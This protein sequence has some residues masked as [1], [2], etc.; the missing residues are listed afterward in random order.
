MADDN[1]PNTKPTV[2]RVRVYSSAFGIF[3]IVNLGLQM[4][5]TLLENAT[6]QWLYPIFPFMG[7]GVLVITILGA[8]YYIRRKLD[9]PK[10]KLWWQILKLILLTITA[11]LLAM[12]AWFSVIEADLE[13]ARAERGDINWAT[14]TLPEPPTIAEDKTTQ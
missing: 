8:N 5:V 10:H 4:A 2:N 6:H 1:A 11:Y 13:R 3:L 12:A 9:K 14:P 7:I